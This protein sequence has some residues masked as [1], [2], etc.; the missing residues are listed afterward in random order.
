MKDE[1]APLDADP[2]TQLRSAF[3]A[4]R[5]LETAVLG[6]Q[7]NEGMVL[8]YGAFYGPGTG[9]LDEAALGPLRR[10]QFP[11][12]GDGGGWWSFLHV[13]D[14]AAATALA[15]ERG[16]PGIYNIVDDEPAAVRDWLPALATMLGA[17]PPRRFPTWLA[18]LA[19][20][21]HLVVM[22]TEARA[23][24]NAK[25]K[26]V[27]AREPAHRSWREGFREVLSQSPQGRFA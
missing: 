26:R 18:R 13:E 17:K 22:M 1:T 4:I 10:R 20:G 27:L 7:G 23:G 9:I 2:P 3:A 6:V 15:I 19:V 25:A 16:A 21:S 24:N 11:L 5:H 12:I 14:A 8:R